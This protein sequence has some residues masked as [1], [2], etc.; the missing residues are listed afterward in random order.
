MQS[1]RKRGR[2]RHTN[3]ERASIVA[4]SQSS[5]LSQAE[6]CIQAG[7]S[8]AT[9]ANWR[10]RIRAETLGSE[11]PLSRGFMEVTPMVSS[12]SRPAEVRIEIKAGPVS[13]VLPMGVPASWV[14]ELVRG[15]Q[16]GG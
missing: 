7:I 4:G 13:L 14:A 2:G 12:M 5:E 11:V 3:Q 16:C 10:R 9:L 1:I 6:Y 8:V 15:L